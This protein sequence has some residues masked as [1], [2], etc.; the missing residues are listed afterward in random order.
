MCL[1]HVAL[2]GYLCKCVFFND[3]LL[4]TPNQIQ[5]RFSFSQIPVLSTDSQVPPSFQMKII[6]KDANHHKEFL[7][8]LVRVP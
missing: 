4:K 8:N 1:G 6:V 7:M 5:T 2:W 3:I